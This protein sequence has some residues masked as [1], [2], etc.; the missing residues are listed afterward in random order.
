MWRYICGEYVY[1]LLYPSLYPSPPPYF[2]Y[3]QTNE[4]RS[5]WSRT[6]TKRVCLGFGLRFVFHFG[7]VFFRVFFR[8]FSVFLQF[9]QFLKKT[10]AYF[11]LTTWAKRRRVLLNDVFDLGSVSVVVGVGVG[12]GGHWLLE[13]FEIPLKLDCSGLCC[14]C[15]GFLEVRGSH[16]VRSLYGFLTP[17]LE[18]YVW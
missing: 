14:C 7:K 4:S 8:V 10:C 2:P 13:I 3:C 11:V 1:T 12:H 16:A 18:F 15:C 17:S 9:V 5:A 6:H